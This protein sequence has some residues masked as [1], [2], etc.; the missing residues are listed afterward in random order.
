MTSER[1]HFAELRWALQFSQTDLTSIGEN[2]LHKIR[3]RLYRFLSDFTE[4]PT[5]RL[6]GPVPDR[7]SAGD[8]RRL[9]WAA[10]KNVIVRLQKEFQQRL[11]QLAWIEEDAVMP[12]I[13]IGPGDVLSLGNARVVARGTRPDQCFEW[14]IM[15][16]PKSSL[17]APTVAALYRH[18]VLSRILRS[19]LRIC[20]ECQTL[21]LVERKPR[22]DRKFHCSNECAQGAA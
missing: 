7:E 22:R 15:W 10:K 9:C 19:Q 6:G 14:Q 1:E 20:P 5:R 18:L 4:Q 16:S 21:F 2:E 8:V 17:R 11:L 12:E 13:P 3:K